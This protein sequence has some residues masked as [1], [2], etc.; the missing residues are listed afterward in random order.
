MH[1]LQ[2]KIIWFRVQW[3]LLVIVCYYSYEFFCTLGASVIEYI[4]DKILLL[5]LV[6]GISGMDKDLVNLANSIEHCAIGK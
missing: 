1:W 2:V 3:G 4:K 5:S 6:F